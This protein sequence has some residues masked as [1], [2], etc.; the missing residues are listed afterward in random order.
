MRENPLGENEA[1]H[2]PSMFIDHTVSV[3]WRRTGDL[4]L[5]CRMN[6]PSLEWDDLAWIFSWWLI[7]IR[8]SCKKRT[9]FSF[10]ET[11][12][13]NNIGCGYDPNFTVREV[14]IDYMF[15]EVFSSAETERIEPLIL[16]YFH[17]DQISFVRRYK[18]N[19]FNASVVDSITIFEHDVWIGKRLRSWTCSRWQRQFVEENWRERNESDISVPLGIRCK[20][21]INR[22]RNDCSY[23]ISLAGSM[24]LYQV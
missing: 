22:D 19:L 11:S 21:Q 3:P 2:V 17:F 14:S 7:Q 10:I 6:V 4:F 12:F 13:F 18:E 20:H 23:S 15:I 1:C 5:E 24:S 9:V 16:K 8:K